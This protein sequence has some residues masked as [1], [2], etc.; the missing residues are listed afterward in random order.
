M[1]RKGLA[2]AVIATILIAGGLGWGI[3]YFMPKIDLFGGGTCN[4]TIDGSFDSGDGWEY[5]D[6]QFIEYLTLDENSS[7]TN[8][9]FYVHLTDDSLYIMVDFCGDITGETEDEWFSVWIDTDNSQSSFKDVVTWNDTTSNPDRGEELLCYIPETES[10]IESTVYKNYNTTL[11]SSDV[12]IKHGFQKSI[13]S[14][15]SHRVFEMK[16]NRTSLTNLNS[17]NFNVGFLGYGTAY[18]YYV[19]NGFWGAPSSF[20]DTIFVSTDRNDI[21]E[22]RFFRCEA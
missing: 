4:P 1:S 9:Y 21:F 8:N 17:T 12:Q 18:I 7:N 22:D 10:L 13:N 11:N 14:E 20:V 3:G 16:I 19:D 2:G 6:Y 15:I 5:A